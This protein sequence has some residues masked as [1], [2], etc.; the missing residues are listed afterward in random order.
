MFAAIAPRGAAALARDQP[1]VKHP[2]L[3][4]I[5]RYLVHL[6]FRFVLTL[7]VDSAEQKGLSSATGG[8]GRGPVCGISVAPMQLTFVTILHDEAKSTYLPPPG[9]DLFRS[10]LMCN[11][12]CIESARQQIAKEK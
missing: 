1:G 6:S 3:S 11:C 2:S 9:Q 4:N 5:R 7:A 8:D 12:W 10:R